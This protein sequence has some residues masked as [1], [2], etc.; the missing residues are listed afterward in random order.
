MNFRLARD[1]LVHLETAA[2]LRASRRPANFSSFK[3]GS[4]KDILNIHKNVILNSFFLTCLLCIFI[5][6]SSQLLK[7]GSQNQVGKVSLQTDL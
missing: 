6:F 4:I 5:L 2:N 1:Q 3:L 7:V